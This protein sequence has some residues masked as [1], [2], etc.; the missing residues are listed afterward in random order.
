MNTPSLCAQLS[1]SR[2]NRRVGLV[3]AKD[4][5]EEA[6]KPATLAPPADAAAPRV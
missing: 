2:R 3:V 5:G 6:A 4:E 1:L